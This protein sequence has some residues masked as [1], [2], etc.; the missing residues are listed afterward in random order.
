[1]SMKKITL[2]VAGMLVAA[3]FAPE[4]S[5]V[6]AFARQVGM[7]C[8]ACHQQHF[9]AINGF[10]RAF[11]S[12]AYTMM[13]AQDK[14]EDQASATSPGLSLPATINMAIVGYMQYGK[15]NGPADANPQTA[16][17]SNSGSLQIPQQVSLFAGGRVG[18]NVGFEAEYALTTA[19]GTNAANSQLIRFKVPFVQDMGTVKT[20]EVPFSTS[21]GV[22]DSFEILNTGAVNVHAFNQNAMPVIS[23]AQ[24]L[25]TGTNAN[26]VAF[27]ANNDSF[28]ANVAKYGANAGTGTSGAPAS[29]YLRGAWMSGDVV[30]SSDF[31]VGFQYWG[32]NSVSDKLLTPASVDTKA[33]AIDAQILSQ[34]ST[35]PLT[36][37]AS[38]ASAQK[39]TNGINLYNNGNAAAAFAKSAFTFGAELGVIPNIATVQLGYR[40][41]KNGQD[42]GVLSSGVAN[43]S[44]ASDNA[45][46]LGATYA[47]ALN[48]RAELTYT[49]S[50]GDVYNYNAVNNPNVLGTNSIIADL[51]FG[52]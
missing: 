16:R 13:G 52:F 22:A 40:W 4:A 19:A 41:G 15:T 34:I 23:A 12:G 44:N 42:A 27:V 39:G 10:G 47:L 7:A 28:F 21:N 17:T 30:P 29:T 2:S 45:L 46:L 9:P 18:E 14:I 20:L 50:S 11:K 6:P 38:Y 35:M 37:V 5:A 24:Y 36:F 26:G 25:G 31:A 8:S 51:A 49:R 43:G 48:V 3:A 1:M 32:G 33:Y